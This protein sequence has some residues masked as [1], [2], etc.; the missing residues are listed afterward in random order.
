VEDPFADSAYDDVPGVQSLSAMPAPLHQPN[1]A[2][3]LATGHH[4][5]D[6]TDTARTADAY[7]MSDMDCFA[8]HDPEWSLLDMGHVD[9]FIFNDQN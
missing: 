6:A 9:S 1:T 4:R 7:A 2:T 3:T 5:H 8:S